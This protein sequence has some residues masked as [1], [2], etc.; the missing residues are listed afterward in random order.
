MTMGSITACIMISLGEM[1]AHL[2]LP[3]GH[4]TMANRFVNPSFSFAM[5]WNYWYNWLFVLPAELNAAAVLI[6]YWND[7]VNPAVWIAICL[8]VASAINLGGTR[9]YGEMEF[10]FAIIKVVT[11]VALIILGIILDAGGGPDHDVIGFRFWV[12]PGPFVQYLG[13]PGV[14]G[15]F[16]GY[17]A[18]LIQASFSYIG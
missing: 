13:I 11:I 7:S 4:I 9:A 18:V 8:V 10:W 14:T 17:W 3:G 2:P 16:L 12:N 6:G 5:G 15:R 1:I